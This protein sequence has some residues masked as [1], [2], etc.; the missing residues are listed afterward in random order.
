MGLIGEEV[1]LYFEATNERGYGIC[2]LGCW[3]TVVAPAGAQGGGDSAA[4]VGGEGEVG[5]DG[6]CVAVLG[7]ESGRFV[8]FVKTVVC[9]PEIL[10]GGGFDTAGYFG[11]VGIGMVVDCLGEFL[12][13][14]EDEIE[15]SVCFDVL[16]GLIPWNISEED[17][18][19]TWPPIPNR[20]QSELAVIL[21][22]PVLS[23]LDSAHCRPFWY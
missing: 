21:A 3:C 4:L 14:I 13:F 8:V 20:N 23:T 19:L 5:L 16:L 6:P 22:S 2:S 11:P 10:V 18:V 15:D 9:V 7:V 17:R 12:G 1:S